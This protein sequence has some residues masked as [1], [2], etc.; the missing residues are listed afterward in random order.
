MSFALSITISP[1][2]NCTFSFWSPTVVFK[3]VPAVPLSVLTVTISPALY[4]EAG[5]PPVPTDV[6]PIAFEIF[7]AT[8]S[9][10]S[11]AL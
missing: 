6:L 11:S 8:A 3:V 10:F 2:P 1:D 4:P 7:F 5:V 9:L